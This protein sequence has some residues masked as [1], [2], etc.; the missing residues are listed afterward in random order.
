MLAFNASNL[1]RS[2]T[3]L[4]SYLQAHLMMHCACVGTNSLYTIAPS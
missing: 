3:L 2:Q 4:E 1:I